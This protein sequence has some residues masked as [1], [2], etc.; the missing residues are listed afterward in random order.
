MSFWN[1]FERTLDSMGE[2]LIQKVMVDAEKYA[3]KYAE[4]FYEEHKEILEQE[5]ERRLTPCSFDEALSWEE[6]NSLAIKAT[7]KFGSSV[8]SMGE[9]SA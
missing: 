8:V 3:E 5:M 4:Q 6:F 1:M 7:K 2:Q 9:I